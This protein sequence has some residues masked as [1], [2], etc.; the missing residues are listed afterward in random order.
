MSKDEK[1]KPTVYR[2]PDDPL[3]IDTD[4]D[5]NEEVLRIARDALEGRHQEAVQAEFQ[6]ALR[7]WGML[8]SADLVTNAAAIPD[9]APNVEP[10]PGDEIVDSDARGLARD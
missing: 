3:G 8:P 10:N 9:R 7:R 4:K 5:F 2:P 1:P 6:A